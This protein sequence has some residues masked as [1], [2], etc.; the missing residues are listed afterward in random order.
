MKK[1]P[2][3][4]PKRSYAF[5]DGSFNPTTKIYGCGGFLIDQFGKRHVIQASSDNEEWAVMRNVAGEKGNGTGKE[6]PDEKA[7]YILRL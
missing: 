1:S 3:K 4:I 7:D 5:V 2:V 6:A